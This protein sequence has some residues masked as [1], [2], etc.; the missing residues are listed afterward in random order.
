ML[1]ILELNLYRISVDTAGFIDFLGCKLEGILNGFTVSCCRSGD[2]SDTA[3][4][5][6]KSV[7]C[8]SLSC[9]SCFAAFCCFCRSFSCCGC[10]CRCAAAAGG[11]R[12]CHERCHRQ[13]K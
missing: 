3:D 11:K 6:C 9:F 10:L 8:R 2:G 1:V 13:A 5:P 7:C 12:C 4:L